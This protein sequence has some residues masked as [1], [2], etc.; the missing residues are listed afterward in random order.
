MKAMLRA[1]SSPSPFEEAAILT[2]PAWVNGAPPRMACRDG[3]HASVDAPDRVSALPGAQER[4]LLERFWRQS[5]G[6]TLVGFNCL[7]FDLPVLL[8]RSLYLGV[9]APMFSLNKYRPG[10]IVDL[11]QRLAY[12][13]T[14]P[15]RSLAFYCT[16]FGIMVPDEVTGSDIGALVAAGEWSRVMTTSVPTWRRRPHSPGVS[17]C[18]TGRGWSQRPGRLTA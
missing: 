11:M 8:R 1:L 10:S 9:R 17:A 7:S 15:Y 13:G 4:D 5:R 6:A 12:Q 3:K 14:L 2:L 16:R 18:S